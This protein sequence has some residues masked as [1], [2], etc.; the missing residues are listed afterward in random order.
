MITEH[1]SMVE[2]SPAEQEAIEYIRDLVDRLKR[3]FK[4]HYGEG[5]FSGQLAELHDVIH[6]YN[7]G[8]FQVSDIDFTS[9]GH[10]V[11]FFS[12]REK[13][14]HLADE[15]EADRSKLWEVKRN[16]TNE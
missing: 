13:N 4:A 8:D 6:R 16:L 12:D 14:L 9:L 5:P 10:A 15:Y 11:R 3:T 7:E 2:T 1:E